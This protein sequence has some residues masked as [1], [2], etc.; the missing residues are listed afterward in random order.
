MDL[1]RVLRAK[2]AGHYE[3]VETRRRL[4][5]EKKVQELGP[6]EWKIV[7]EMDAMMDEDG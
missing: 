3:A 2:L 6:D 7:L 1:N 4:F 5:L